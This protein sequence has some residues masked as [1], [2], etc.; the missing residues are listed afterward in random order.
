[1]ACSSPPE[2]PWPLSPRPTREPLV[3]EIVLPG[4]PL[5]RG[6]AHL[7]GGDAPIL[8]DVLE[9]LERIRTD[10]ESK[11]LFL[12]LG[13]MG[14]A[15]GRAGALAR[16]LN[17]IRESGK[18]VHCHFD[19]ADN[20]SYSVLA[21]ACDRIS[22][23]PAGLIDLVGVLAHVFYVRELLAHV[24]LEADLIQ[25]GRFKGA[26]DTFTADAMP[27]EVAESLGSLLDDMTT[28]LIDAVAAGRDL[29][30]GGVRAL[31]DR[32]PFTAAAA[33][34][35]R[36]VDDVGFDDEAREH[37]RRAAQVERVERVDLH[38]APAPMGLADL[39]GALAGNLPQTT[40]SGPRVA[41]VHLEGHISD[42]DELEAGGTQS[43]PF[44]RAMRR[45]AD[46]ADVKAVVLRVDS[47]GG[48]ALASDRMWHAVRRVAARKPV[49]ASIGDMAASGGYYVAAASP[50]LAVERASTVGSIGVVGGKVV[51]SGLADQIGIHA[52]VLAR[53]NHAGWSSPTRPFSESERALFERMLGETYRRFLGRI[54]DVR[55]LSMDRLEQAAEGR[56]MS[57][58]RAVLAGLAD[59]IAGLST[60]LADAKSRGGLPPDAP[61]ETWPPP[62]TL[63]ESIA[64][65]LGGSPSTQLRRVLVDLSRQRPL[66]TATAIAASLDAGERVVLALPFG[67]VIQ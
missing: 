22:M 29:P 52:V 16:A 31:L 37:A 18:P 35:A 63:L 64:Q 54:L 8:A 13:P 10:P 15:W 40:G 58:D 19:V 24:G 44:V 42:G 27:P 51:A 43:G 62:R 21:Q 61:V 6:T 59:R 28:V 36:L 5:E 49:L 38:R 45:L 41:L 60:V 56:I 25:I 7:V 26:A 11:G 1:V 55:E 23:T 4:A 2:D 14:S 53:G 34:A 50:E 65:N 30:A 32:G 48:S 66:A 67:L 47:P 46:D 39:L 33:S 3:R 12:Q 57:G 17:S 20:V 9:R